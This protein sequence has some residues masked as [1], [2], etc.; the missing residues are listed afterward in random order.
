MSIQRS[1]RFLLL[2]FVTLAIPAMLFAQLDV[3]VTVAPPELVAYSQPICPQNGYL[4]TPGY[5]AYGPGGYFWVPGAWVEPPTVGL[6]WTKVRTVAPEQAC[7][8]EEA[9]IPVSPNGLGIRAVWKRETA[10]V[11]AFG[12]KEMKTCSG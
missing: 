8:G 6:L 9:L 5:W 11:L 10:D 7:L 12:N 1:I 2:L 4:W 3:S